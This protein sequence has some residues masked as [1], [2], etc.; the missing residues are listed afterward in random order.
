MARRRAARIQET[1]VRETRVQTTRIQTAAGWAAAALTGVA[2]ALMFAPSIPPEPFPHADAVA[3]VGLFGAVAFAVAAALGPGF[4]WTHAALLML[5][6][7]GVEAAQVFAP[8]RSLEL[9]DLAANLA[10][11]TFGCAGAMWIGAGRAVPAGDPSEIAD[12][13]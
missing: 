8:A 5:A 2:A 9:S 11:A 12:G 3:H 13:S 6:A 10:G 4:A 1:R 7:M